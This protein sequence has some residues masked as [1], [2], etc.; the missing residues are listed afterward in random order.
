MD[1]FNIHVD[2]TKCSIARNF[3]DTI[4]ATGLHQHVTGST[5]SSGH[6]LDLFISRT[7]DNDLISDLRILPI[8]FSD[9]HLIRLKLK[10][11]MS[12]GTPSTVSY[13]QLRKIDVTDFCEDIRKSEINNLKST[14]C[15][16]HIKCF[17]N[18]LNN[19]LDKHAPIRTKTAS[20]PRSQPWFDSTILEARRVKRLN[21]RKWTKT[22]LT[23]HHNAFKES[24]KHN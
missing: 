13:R 7:E 17:N 12:S 10:F 19:L 1:L 22:G 21:E 16:E 15:D 14:S 3:T 4:S 2:N 9:H 24:A 20:R 6:T 23:V 11:N 8:S 18:V 5:H